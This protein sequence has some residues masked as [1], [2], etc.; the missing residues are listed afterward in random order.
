[1][2]VWVTTASIAGALVVPA[3]AALL[4]A[5]HQRLALLRRQRLVQRQARVHAVAAPKRMPFFI[6]HSMFVRA[7]DQSAGR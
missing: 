7:A 3:A 5:L 4:R 1:M 2:G 6:T